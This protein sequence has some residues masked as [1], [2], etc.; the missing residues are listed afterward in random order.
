MK[1]LKFYFEIKI[2]VVLIRDKFND[3]VKYSDCKEEEE[4][5]TLCI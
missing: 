2:S 4:E 1:N 3:R 5:K